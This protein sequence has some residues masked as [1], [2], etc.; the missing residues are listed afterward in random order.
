[1]K[2]TKRLEHKYLI[3]YLDYHKIINA[4]RATMIHDQHGDDDAYL[5]N[6]IYLD[7]IVFTGAADK[8]FGN[9]LHKKYRIRHYNDTSKKKLE[10]KYK[11][12]NESTKYSTMIN[13]E[14]FQAIIKQN[15]DVLEP[16]FDDQL[17]RRFTLDM[18]RNNLMPKMYIKYQREAYKD[19]LDNIRLTFDH[20]LNAERFLGK[21]EG[22]EMKLMFDTS[23]ILEVKYEHYMPS[24]LKELLKKITLNQIAYSKYFMGY[25]SLEF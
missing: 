18:L 7:D 5:V 8:A 22:I 16:Y 20:S 24:T 9:Q 15:L 1:M 4:V 2:C 10:L 11:E 13:D 17:I 14:V 21:E 6:S 23:L 12:G 3:S 19:E 25:N